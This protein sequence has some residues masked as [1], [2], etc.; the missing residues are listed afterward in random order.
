MERGRAGPCGA[1]KPGLLTEPLEGLHRSLGVIWYDNVYKA[2]P[3]AEL[4]VEGLA[5]DAGWQGG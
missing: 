2:C 5:E 1:S 4:I 3:P